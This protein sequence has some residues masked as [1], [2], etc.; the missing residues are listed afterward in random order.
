MGLSSTGPLA[1]GIFAGAQSAGMVSAGSVLAGIQSAAMTGPLLPV[2]LGT[3]AI[4]AAAYFICSS[5]TEDVNPGNTDVS[6]VKDTTNEGSGNLL[7]GKNR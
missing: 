3:G 6:I 7:D 1:G 2:F 4:G 5:F